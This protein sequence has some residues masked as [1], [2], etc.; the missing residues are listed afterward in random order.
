MPHP[1]GYRCEWSKNVGDQ[2]LFSWRPQP[3][4]DS[5]VALGSVVTTSEDPPARELGEQHA[6][7]VRLLVV[8]TVYFAQDIKRGG[9]GGVRASNFLKEVMV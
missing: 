8:R 3:P 4:N 2:M 6:H 9:H 7:A 1:R 5:F